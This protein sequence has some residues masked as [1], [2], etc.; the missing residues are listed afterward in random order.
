MDQTEAEVR[1]FRH[2]E[3]I[4]RLKEQVAH[5]NRMNKIGWVLAPIVIVLATHFLWQ[6]YQL[7]NYFMRFGEEEP[8]TDVMPNG[9][10]SQAGPSTYLELA[11]NPTP[12][13]SLR[14]GPNA[15]RLAVVRD[16]LVVESTDRHGRPIVKVLLDNG[17][18]DR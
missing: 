13:L 6:Q 3:E 7:P 11:N 12:G 1:H 16:K 8:Y 18:A 5:L 14:D 4:R 15:Y 17:D 9:M 2:E 10:F